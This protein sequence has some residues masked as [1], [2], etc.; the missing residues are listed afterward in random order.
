[1]TENGALFNLEEWVTQYERHTHTL[2]SDTSA[3]SSPHGR[4]SGSFAFDGVESSLRDSNAEN[5]QGM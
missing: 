2:Q 1:M 5:G 3:A 4:H